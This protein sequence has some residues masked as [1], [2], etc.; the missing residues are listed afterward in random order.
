MGEA[1]THIVRGDVMERIYFQDESKYRGSA[2][3]LFIP[4]TKEELIAYVKEKSI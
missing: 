1:F 2:D 3:A 4:E